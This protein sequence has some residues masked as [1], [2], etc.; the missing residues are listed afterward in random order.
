MRTLL[1][2]GDIC[3]T[4]NEEVPMEDIYEFLTSYF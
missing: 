4:F 2:L 1:Y 3:D